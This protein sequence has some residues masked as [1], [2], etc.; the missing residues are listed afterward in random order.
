MKPG[1]QAQV[2]SHNVGGHG[3][4]PLL[5]VSEFLISA[6]ELLAVALFRVLSEHPALLSS[7][8]KQFLHKVSVK[9]LCL[10]S[11]LTD[12]LTRK[13]LKAALEDLAF[14]KPVSPKQHV[15][16]QRKESCLVTDS[17]TI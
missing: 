8:S 4:L 3:L 17:N 6:T 7:S 10:F 12:D 16:G 1:S 2:H 5:L 9:S 15:L 11:F 14:S 13:H